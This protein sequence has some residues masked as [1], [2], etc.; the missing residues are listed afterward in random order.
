MAAYA[1]NSPRMSA[2]E[3]REQLLD[4]TTQIVVQH[5]FHGV[6][7]D[8]V[9]RRA[10]I[11]RAVVYQHFGALPAL[12]EAVVQRETS[13][14]LAHVSQA[15]FTDLSEG[16]PREHVLDSLGAYLAA[17]RDHPTTWSLVLMPPEGAPEILRQSIARGRAKIVAR[18]AEAVQ[19]A[20]VPGDSSGHAELT[21]T[22][23][24]S[25][26]DGYAR[27]VLADP[28]RYAPER[29][30]GHARW[31]LQHPALDSA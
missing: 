22:A 16:D 21:A 15:T 2:A 4:V 18:L 3:R 17:V 1:R 19:P 23:L 11:T 31:L 25:I 29:L 14:A 20:L 12:L 13:R 26:S 6:S 7:I 8:L 27:L 10:G 5:G 24:S 28:V 9:A 30:L